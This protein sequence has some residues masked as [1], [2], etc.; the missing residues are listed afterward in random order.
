MHK[1]SEVDLSAFIYTCFMKISPES[2][3]QMQCSNNMT[4]AEPILF[5][6]NHTQLPH[7]L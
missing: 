7:Q 6:G 3:E 4:A 1:V 2:S 5:T